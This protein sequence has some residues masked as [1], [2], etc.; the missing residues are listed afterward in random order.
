MLRSWKGRGLALLVTASLMACGGGGGGTPDNNSAPK[1][2]D[3]PVSVAPSFADSVLPELSVGEGYDAVLSG[4]AQGQGVLRYQWLRNGVPITGATSEE[5]VLKAV[6]LS[7]NGASFTLQASNASGTAVSQPTVLKVTS[8]AQLFETLLQQLGVAFTMATTPSAAFDTTKLTAKRSG[9]ICV[10][11]TASGV[12]LDG[13]SVDENRDTIL[14]GQTRTLAANFDHC[15]VADDT[16]LGEKFSLTISG[17]A[18]AEFSYSFSGTTLSL[19]SITTLNQLSYDD[20]KLQGNGKFD[21]KL[22]TNVASGINLND[23]NYMVTPVPGATITNLA[24]KRTLTLTG[25]Q[26]A[27]QGTKVVMSKLSFNLG[28]V[29][30][31][32]DGTQGS[33]LTLTGN[34]K[35]IATTSTPA[36][37]T[38]T[39]SITGVVPEF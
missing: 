10:S 6:A 15:V 27:L 17:N 14:P 22:T 24:S 20:A 12:T 28:G 13:R 30:Y 32:L 23:I 18:S 1:S 9:A 29:S 2:Q 16:L 5:L 34:G 26:F 37:G 35:T 36:G 11:G 33:T 39:T 31:V 21:A 4:A 8:K 25:G 7:D 3:P 38:P 19:N